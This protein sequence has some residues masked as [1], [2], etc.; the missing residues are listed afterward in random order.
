MFN[1]H[2]SE[3]VVRVEEEGFRLVS[4]TLA[5]VEWLHGYLEWVE[6]AGEG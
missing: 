5:V 3:K 4:S 6:E 2:V 1:L